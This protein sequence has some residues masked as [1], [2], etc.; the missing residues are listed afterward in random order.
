MTLRIGL[1][2]HAFGWPNLGVDA[3]MQKNVDFYRT[4][5]EADHI[6][7]K[8]KFFPSCKACNSNIAKRPKLIIHGLWRV[9]NS[10]KNTC[11]AFEC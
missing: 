8:L 2:W 7:E 5:A 3:L 11:R 6:G 4:M 9:L 1:L 10:R